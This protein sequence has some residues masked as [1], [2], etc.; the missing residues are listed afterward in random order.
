M[1][2]YDDRSRFLNQGKPVGDLMR[3]LNNGYRVAYEFDKHDW[4]KGAPFLDDLEGGTRN[5]WGLDLS[6]LDNGGGGVWESKLDD[7]QDHIL[8]HVVSQIKDNEDEISSFLAE[9]EGDAENHKQQTYR[10]LS[11]AW[12]DEFAVNDPFD[13]DADK[14]MRAAEWKLTKCYYAIYK[15]VS[16]ILRIKF[17]S[18]PENHMQMWT[19][20]HKQILE[21]FGT[22]LY[23][24]PFMQFP[25]KSNWE[26]EKHYQ[27][28]VPYPMPEKKYEQQ[29]GKQSRYAEDTLESIYDDAKKIPRFDEDQVYSFFDL[30]MKVRHWANYWHGGVF[31]RLY[32]D[33]YKQAIDDAVR[34]LCFT[35]LSVAEAT[36]IVSFGYQEFSYMQ[37][38]YRRSC[39][40]G[41]MPKS[42]SLVDRRD[43]VYEQV[44]G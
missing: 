5:K 23:P 12:R 39:Q 38:E 2:T 44:W 33:G 37:K 27:W 15:S 13:G 30:M 16:A 28:V 26:D 22:K 14:R 6:K 31:S 17:D 36:T 24:Y 42:H 35:I 11:N 20:N 21:R 7:L 3:D 40:R 25:Q 19:K 9:F 34:L 41:M 43:E 18:L 1:R 32:G 4:K 29:Q 8:Y 10:N